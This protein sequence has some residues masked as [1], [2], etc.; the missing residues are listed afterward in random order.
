MVQQGDVLLLFTDGLEEAKRLL[1]DENFDPMVVTQEMIDRKLVPEDLG[2]GHDGEEFHMTRVH[3]VIKAVQTRGTYRLEKTLNPVR[4]EVLEFDFSTC[5][6]DGR[7]LVLAVIAAEKLFR[8]YPDPRA[9]ATN[10][11]RV[12]SIVDD[13]LREHFVQYRQYFG[14]PLD[15]GG[16]GGEYGEGATAV[17]AEYR[18]YTHLMEDEQYD[19]LTMLSVRR[20]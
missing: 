8:I 9:G 3:D 10:R 2:L 15:E 16:D 14:H 17:S 4:D 11:V 5:T 18:V 19:D 1:R 20:K 12:D 7:D 6:P 13:F